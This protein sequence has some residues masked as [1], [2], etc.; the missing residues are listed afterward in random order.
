MKRFLW[1]VLLAGCQS[2]PQAPAPNT[3]G[4]ASTTPVP[5][6]AQTALPVTATPSGTSTPVAVP[7]ANAVE[8]ARL[9]ADFA[10]NG[11]TNR[12]RAEMLLA[13]LFAAGKSGLI[14]SWNA[15]PEGG[16]KFEV[17]YSIDTIA[18]LSKPKDQPKTTRQSPFEPM[19]RVKGKGIELSWTYDFKDQTCLPRDPATQALYELKPRLDEQGLEAVLPRTWRTTAVQVPTLVAPS[20]LE[21]V[22]DAPVAEESP[23]TPV[24]PVLFTGFLGEGKERRAVI[25]HAGQSYSLAVGEKE[26]GFLVKSMEDSEVQIEYQGSTMR[27]EP[28]N[29]WTPGEF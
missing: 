3:A 1:L 7:T 14:V 22:P 17:V 10:Y 9:T 20:P 8:A 5:T 15:Y 6:V 28:G 29:Q 18:S 13:H 4:T 24:E 26:G 19:P 21:D 16:T 23:A 11:L 12:A 27:L 2:A 25:T